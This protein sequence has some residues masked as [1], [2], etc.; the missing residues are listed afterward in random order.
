MLRSSK[1]RQEK[2]VSVDG[3]GRARANCRNVGP[4]RLAKRRETVHW[5]QSRRR[6]IWV[7]LAMVTVIVTVHVA[8]L[9]LVHGSNEVGHGWIPDRFGN[10]GSK[11]RL[12]G[13][14]MLSMKKN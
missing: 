1:Y 4:V 13:L 8:G 3:T 10:V 12:L 6:R 9:A 14:G 7:T 11:T 2:V 5:R